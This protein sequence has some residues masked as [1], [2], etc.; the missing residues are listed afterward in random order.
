MLD[1]VQQDGIGQLTNMKQAFV[2][3]LASKKNGTIYIGV[4]SDLIKRIHQ[5]K[6]D[7]IEGFTKKYGVHLLVWFEVHDEIREAIQREK[8]IKYWRRTWKL[9]LIEKT[10]PHWHDLYDELQG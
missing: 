8:Q 2:F 9:E 3:I 1:Q 6:N 7:L 4:T 5:H 10:N